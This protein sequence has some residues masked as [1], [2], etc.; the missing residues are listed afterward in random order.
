MPK[1]LKNVNV[2]TMI[3]IFTIEL[4]FLAMAIIISYNQPTLHGTLR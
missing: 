3:F 4:G 1:A 2:K